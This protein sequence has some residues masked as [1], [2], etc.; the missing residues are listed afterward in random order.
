MSRDKATLAAE[1]KSRNAYYHWIF[2]QVMFKEMKNNGRNYNLLLNYLKSVPFRWS[3]DRDSNRAADGR[4]LRYIFEVETGKE[5]LLGKEPVNCLEVFIGLS[6]RM[7]DDIFEILP[8]A[9]P[10][11]FFWMMMEN[12]GLDTFTNECFDEEDVEL[13]L[14]KIL[15]RKYS[16]TGNGGLFPLKHPKKDQRNVEL[17]YQMQAYILENFDF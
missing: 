16:K 9:S 11:R 13:I 1:V 3:I 4:N 2:E 17:W 15:D 7:N 12:C 6:A 8:G 10:A 14:N 5:L